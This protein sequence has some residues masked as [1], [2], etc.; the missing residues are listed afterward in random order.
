MRNKEKSRQYDINYRKQHR[1]AIRIKNKLYRRLPHVRK[2]I[3]IQ[4]KNYLHEYYLSN[5]DKILRR[6]KHWGKANRDKRRLY[7][8]KYK[9]KLKNRKLGYKPKI[10]RTVEQFIEYCKARYMPDTIRHYEKNMERF[11]VYLKRPGTKNSDYHAR[12]Y[13]ENKKPIHQRDFSWTKDYIKIR[14]MPDITKDVIIKY[15]SYVN[16]DELNKK[17]N[18]PLNQSEKETRLYPLKTFL[19]FC[20]RKGYI[21]GNLRKFIYVPPREKKILKRILTIQEM[22]RLLNAP[23][24]NTALGVRDRALLELAYSGLRANEILRLNIK[25]ADLTTNAVTII[26]GKGN[27]DRVI[28]MTNEAIYWI[29]RWLNRRNEFIKSKNDSGYLFI[30]KHGKPMGRKNF[31]VLIKKYTKKAGIPLDISPHDLRRTTATH[32]AQNGAPIRL[33]QALLG[34]TTLKVTTKYLRLTDDTIKKEHKKTHP[35]S[36]R[37]LYYGNI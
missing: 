13:R 6:S 27:K 19:L 3:R 22:K 7:N 8:R 5:R 35:A 28:P 15:V 37:K 9:A 30:T 11:L 4:R 34:H 24:E 17:T 29:K 31:S 16:H 32:L 18:T 21:K 23:K 36:R 20:E 14:H 12:Y 33:I 26:K 1:V 2:R 10:K 25:Y